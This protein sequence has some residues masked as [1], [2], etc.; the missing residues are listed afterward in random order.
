MHGFKYLVV[1]SLVLTWFS[2][3][4]GQD[5]VKIDSAHYKVIYDGPTARVRRS[6]PGR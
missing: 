4:M 3:A 2:P 1:A 5:P 6:C